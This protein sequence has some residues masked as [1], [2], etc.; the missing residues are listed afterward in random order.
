VKFDL[1]EEKI[2]RAPI[3][4]GAAVFFCPNPD[5]NQPHLLLLDEDHAPLAHF[6]ISDAFFQE[7]TAAMQ[8]RK[9]Q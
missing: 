6:V 4:E 2:L 5:C 7:L 9:N 8:R 3:A 1:D